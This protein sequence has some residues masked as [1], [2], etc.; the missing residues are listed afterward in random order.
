LNEYRRK[1]YSKA[2]R[3]FLEAWKCGEYDHVYCYLPAYWVA[4]SYDAL[5]VTDRAKEWYGIFLREDYEPSRKEHLLY[6]RFAKD[7]LSLHEEDD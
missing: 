2:L 1:S 5:G 7:Y 6:V 3:Y 4:N